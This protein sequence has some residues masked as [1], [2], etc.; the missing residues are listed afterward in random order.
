L[1]AVPWEAWKA[2]GSYL[3]CPYRQQRA[4][5]LL[6]QALAA[7]FPLPRPLEK[8][9][10]SPADAEHA[11]AALRLLSALVPNAT[12][13]L[14]RRVLGVLAALTGP[15]ADLPAARQAAELLL[16]D[17]ALRT[18]SA[19]RDRLAV[20]L[21]LARTQGDSPTEVAQAAALFRTAWSQLP[22]ENEFSVSERYQ[23]ILAPALELAERTQPDHL[24]ATAKRDLGWL[25][26]QL[27]ELL[28]NNLYGVD[29]P[30]P[31]PRQKAVDAFTTA[32]KF[33][34]ENA[35]WYVGRARARHYLREKKTPQER[36]QVLQAIE[37]D[38][39]R[40]Q[41]L[42]PSLP[43]GHHWLGYV[44]ILQ[45]RETL[46]LA[47]RLRLAQRAIDHFERARLLYDKPGYDAGA[48][49]Q[50]FTS[51]SATYLDLANHWQAPNPA[52]RRAKQ[53]EL[54]EQALFWAE[55]AT[56]DNPLYPEKAWLAVAHAT[57][58]FGLLLGDQTAY[59]RAIEAF[60]KVI[61]LRG[62]EA[63][64]FLGQGRALFRSQAALPP[65]KADFRQAE[66]RLEQARR[67]AKGTFAEAEALH[68]LGLLSARRGDWAKA[69]ERLEAALELSQR[70]ERQGWQ[71]KNLQEL[72]E[73]VLE[74]AAA[75]PPESSADVA[76]YAQARQWQ[77]EVAKLAPALGGPLRLRIMLGEA[78][79]LDRS[80]EALKRAKKAEQVRVVA[81]RLEQVAEEMTRA[82]ERVQGAFWRAR[83]LRHHD[84][85]GEA[86]RELN[87]VL[88]DFQSPEASVAMT[89]LQIERLALYLL[90]KPPEDKIRPDQETWLRHLNEARATVAVAA[91]RGE[92]QSEELAW[93]HT[94]LGTT[95][96]A[97]CQ[98]VAEAEQPGFIDTGI[99]E[100]RQALAV[101]TDET[102]LIQSRLVDLLW[103]KV[104]GKAYEEGRR[105]EER[106]ALCD[107]AI[108][109]LGKLRKHP[110]MRSKAK[111]FEELADKFKLRRKGA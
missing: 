41:E 70:F 50:L 104:N 83:A 48:R 52:A 82:G 34:A 95:Y 87:G 90:V 60:G 33:D 86:I 89:L 22:S 111:Q 13:P 36:R 8:P 106:Q 37:A 39:Q 24:T 43:G 29:W 64:G 28:D 38:A 65:A 69:R 16:D 63:E 66:A 98:R 107:E 10:D 17:P 20:Q 79:R 56:E 4:A 75:L 54:L 58:D 105:A 109:L 9:F 32:L 44:R 2:E 62:D 80:S 5:Q 93:C 76:L 71:V 40:A 27:G 108:E 96:W 73:L 85:F 91:D 97:M 61:E 45:A 67:F 78:A 81:D 59:G 94:V 19:W 46:D 100:L 99:K 42:N 1:L 74:Q 101:E 77:G 15:Q 26:A 12:P 14:P 55:R 68:W 88:A 7:R 53:K 31:D 102:P 51:M 47:E 103:L 84:R 11:A 35:Q 21:A 18:P 25:C 49:A 3:D 23:F 6:E 72:V 92:L 110:A 30:F 57:E